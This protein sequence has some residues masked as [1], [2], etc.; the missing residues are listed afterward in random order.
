MGEPELVAEPVAAAS[1]FVTATGVPVPAGA[2]VVVYDFGA[3]T[4]DA[5]V[6]RRTAGGWEVLASEGLPDAGGLDVD[7]AIVAYLAATYTAGRPA[8]VRRLERPETAGDRRANRLLWEDVRTAKEVLSRASTTYIHLPLIEDDAPLGREQLERLARPVVDRTVALTRKVIAEAAPGGALA[9]VF[10]V[11]GSSRMPWSPPC[12]TRRSGSPPTVIEQPELV[13]AE[14]SA[15]PLATTGA[16][17]VVAAAGVRQAPTPHSGRPPRPRRPGRPRR[18]KTGVPCRRGPRTTRSATAAADPRPHG[19]VYGTP[20]QHGPTE[21]PG[22]CLRPRAC[23]CSGRTSNPARRVPRAPPGQAS[24]R[25]RSRPC[26]AAPLQA[27]R[28]RRRM[29]RRRAAG[30]RA[31]GRRLVDLRPA[32]PSNGPTR[33]RPGRS[34]PPEPA[35]PTRPAPRAPRAPGQART[36][37]NP[38][39]PA[40]RAHKTRDSPRRDPHPQTDR[41]QGRAPRHPARSAGP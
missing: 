25:S 8:E 1:Y 10:L 17:P 37:V 39:F 33:I 20:A 6:V 19:A 7:A 29:G 9:G 40:G 23:R 27:G 32:R 38:A 12:C 28:T 21:R 26:P 2:C 30:L 16:Q 5:S 4:F 41:P 15:R 13:V 11:G 34:P 36:G 24:R 22:K 35:P 3:G 18:A 31:A 14:G